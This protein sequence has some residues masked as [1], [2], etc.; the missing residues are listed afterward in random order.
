MAGQV[1]RYCRRFYC[2]IYDYIVNGLANDTLILPGQL[3]TA[4]A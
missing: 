4:D 3:G 1:K 2:E